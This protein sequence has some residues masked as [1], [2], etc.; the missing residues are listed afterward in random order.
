MEVS[1]G[2]W[3][4]WCCEGLGFSQC[5]QR[6]YIPSATPVRPVQSAAAATPNAPATIKTPALAGQEGGTL[7]DS[8]VTAHKS[9]KKT[10]TK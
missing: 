9:Q 8:T 10:K 6:S 3:L 5:I 2:C 1:E 7:T 4:F